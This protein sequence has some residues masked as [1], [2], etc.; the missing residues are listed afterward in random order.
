MRQ[1]DRKGPRREIAEEVTSHQEDTARVA[2]RDR[3]ATA[4]RGAQVVW[5]GALED[6][7][8]KIRLEA[9][10]WEGQYS[11][12]SRYGIR[13]GSNP[14]ELFG[15]G[16]A[17][18]FAMALAEQLDRE[19]GLVAES[20]RIR[21]HVGLSRE[22]ERDR[23][24]LIALDIELRGPDLSEGRLSELILAARQRCPI[25]GLLPAEA[26]VLRLIN[27]EETPGEREKAGISNLSDQ[28]ESKAVGV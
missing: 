22:G 21:A 24:G 9:A 25:A 14:E 23:L 13:P 5:A 18:S 15:A 4:V 27:P 7:A 12:E 28:Q 20:L 17:A 10:G 6:G 16:L 2:E 11:F 26:L 1:A 3:N 19:E 8:G